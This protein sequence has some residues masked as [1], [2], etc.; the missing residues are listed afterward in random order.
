MMKVATLVAATL[1]LGASAASAQSG[2]HGYG[3]REP[4][5]MRLQR[6][7]GTLSLTPDQQSSV[8]KIFAA[9]R[10]AAESRGKDSMAAA[11]ALFDQIRADTFDEAAIRR[12]AAAVGGFEADRAVSEAK[13]LGEVRAQLTE[14]Q[15]AQLDKTLSD[16]DGMME[17]MGPMPPRDHHR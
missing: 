2:P 7:V 11:K 3:G 8:D 14:E 13:M 16:H 10:E 4:G 5:A 9:H 6:V 12:A 1:I 17:P 15:K